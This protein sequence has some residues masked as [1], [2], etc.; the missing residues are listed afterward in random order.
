MASD[1]AASKRPAKD[2]IPS[3]DAAKKRKRKRSGTSA[4]TPNASV[5]ADGLEPEAVEQAF[6]QQEAVE[7]DEQPVASTSQA[8]IHPDRQQAITAPALDGATAEES[9]EAFSSALAAQHAPSSDTPAN[10]D[11]SFESID[12]TPHSKKAIEDLGFKQMTE[13][14]ARCIP[15]LM[16]GKD[17]LG[18]AK[19]GSGKTLAF[20][21][22]AIEMLS[23]LKFKPRNGQ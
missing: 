21:L 3:G 6:A 23:K 12:F 5:V 7:E 4:P 10:I 1:K 18:A 8:A 16:A 14:Q 13:I 19:T 17:V 2:S 20:L 9:L 22:P 15:P 11:L